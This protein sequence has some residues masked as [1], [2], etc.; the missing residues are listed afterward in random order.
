MT[1]AERRNEI[2]RILT[3]RR[4]ETAARLASELGV[5]V[6]TIYRDILALTCEYPLDTRRGNG[7]CIQLAEW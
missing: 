6:S 7:G 1:S 4:C 5:S 2:M 3:V